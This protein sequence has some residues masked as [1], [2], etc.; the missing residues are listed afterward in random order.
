MGVWVESKSLLL[1]P[2]SQTTIL[3]NVFGALVFALFLNQRPFKFTVHKGDVGNRNLL[4][5]YRL[6][7]AFIGA[8]A[9][10]FDVHLRYHAPHPFGSLRM[11]L[12]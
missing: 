6:T 9:K 4:G 1:V 7:F 10:T 2:H 8:V 11:T 5:T 12:G 3:P